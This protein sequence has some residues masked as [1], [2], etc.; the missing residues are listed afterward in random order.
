MAHKLNVF[1]FVEGKELSGQAY[2]RGG[3]TIRGAAVNVFAPDGEKLAETKTDD[4]G[5]FRIPVK[6]R[7]DHRVVVD[8][9]GGHT[10]EYT[11]PASELP[12]DLPARD[13]SAVL[14]AAGTP[15]PPTTVV[16]APSPGVPHAVHGDIEADVESLTHQVAELRKDLDAFQ[17]RL[18]FQ[19]VLGGVGYILG[20]A[21]LWYYLSAVRTRGGRPQ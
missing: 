2:A 18:R 5:N 9:G 15:P 14:A 12:G 3:E 21:G 16:P 8:A 19:D 4:E 1:A 20:L 6:Y 7:C 10:A 13:R 11:V 17:Q